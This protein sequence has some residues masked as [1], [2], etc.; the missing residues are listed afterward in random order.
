MEDPGYRPRLIDSTLATLIAELPAVMVTGPRAAGKTTTAGRHVADIARLDRPREA[1]VFRADPD[2]ALSGYEEPTLLDEWQEV[3]TVLGA[4]KRAVDRDPRPGRFILTGSARADLE[5][6]TW[7][8]TGRVVRVPMYG[9]T[10]RELN[11]DAG[12]DSFLDRLAS[13]GT[14]NLPSDPP[15]LRGY[16]ELALRSG[17]PEPALSMNANARTRWLEGYVDQLLTRDAAGIE[18][19]RDPARLRRYFEAYALNTAGIVSDATLL[20]AAGV[21]R[22]TAM[23][24]EQLLANLFVVEAMAAWTSNRLRRL[25][26]GPK[27]YFVDPAIPA[28][29]LKLDADA[30]LRDGDLLGRLLDTFVAAQLRAECASS[31]ARPRL[32]H[33]R[34]EHGRREVDVLAEIG[35]RDLLAFEV[36]ADAAPGPDAARHLI[37]LRDRLGER[38][39]G[40]IV[41]HSGPRAFELDEKVTAAPICA[42]WG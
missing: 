12:G 21:N 22:R 5:A 41:F 39:M 9:M 3:P 6:A 10:V 34:E 23:A 38:F 30:V 15:D 26:R 35:G 11:G 36:K 28:A 4:V 7:P 29:A 42:L 32:Y 8:G 27:R 2:V 17:F 31:D 40:G 14:V 18:P 33:L 25:S 37:W 24:Y 13:G 19:R 20:R 1:A 16:V